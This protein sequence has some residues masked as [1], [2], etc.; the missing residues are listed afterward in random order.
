MAILLSLVEEALYLLNL[1]V[2]VGDGVDIPGYDVL[3]VEP[4]DG[5]PLGELLPVELL[6]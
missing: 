4:D 6:A 2:A 5:D 1:P 3:G